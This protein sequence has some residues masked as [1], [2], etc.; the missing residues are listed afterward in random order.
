[1]RKAMDTEAGRAQF[2]EQAAGASIRV[3][4]AT[5]RGKAQT[6]ILRHACLRL[7]AHSFPPEQRARRAGRSWPR[8]RPRTVVASIE[9]LAALLDVDSF[10]TALRDVNI[11]D[12]ALGGTRKS[13]LRRALEAVRTRVN[14]WTEC[15]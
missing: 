5:P 3:D 11:Y 15:L 14:V 10:G 12:E 4:L 7:S 9:A 13:R 6:F 2:S 8:S 1:M